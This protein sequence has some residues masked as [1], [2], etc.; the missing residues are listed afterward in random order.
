MSALAFCIT[1][2]PDAP[3]TVLALF[4]K[5]LSYNNLSV[6][7]FNDE[8]VTLSMPEIFTTTRKEVK[9]KDDHEN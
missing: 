4:T 6:F 5:K 2:P 3:L 9:D 1:L 8:L 7:L